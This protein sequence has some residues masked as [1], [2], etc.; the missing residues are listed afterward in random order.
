MLQAKDLPKANELETKNVLSKLFYT[1]LCFE[2]VEEGGY[3]V[4]QIW[5]REVDESF[6]VTQPQL[7]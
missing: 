6:K 7:G 3:T 1:H 2:T 4:G 5:P